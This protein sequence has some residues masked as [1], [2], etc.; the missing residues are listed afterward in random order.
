MLLLALPILLAACGPDVRPA[1]PSAE[2]VV[3]DNEPFRLDIPATDEDGKV[4]P[5]IP[6]RAVAT[7]DPAVLVLEEGLDLPR[8]VG[9]GRARLTLEADGERADLPVRCQLVTTVKVAPPEVRLAAGETTFMEAR[10]AW[11]VLD[12]EGQPMPD[13]PV[14]ISAHDEDVV[15]ASPDGR[16]QAKLPGSTFVRVTAAR[17]SAEVPVVVGDV[18]AKVDRS[19]GGRMLLPQGDVEIRLVG[20]TGKAGIKL[21]TRNACRGV[22]TITP[23]QPLRCQIT[24]AAEG[25]VARQ[26]RETGRLVAIRWPAPEVKP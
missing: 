19:T 25:I 15:K 2:R 26:P 11:E 13:K 1:I 12:G 23:E 17:K 10:L 3:Q 14:K 6:V 5:D 24:I 8:C 18:I 21:P 20:G 4:H 16:L 22:Q 9:T 7:S